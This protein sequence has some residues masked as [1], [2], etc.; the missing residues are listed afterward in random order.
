[1]IPWMS[2]LIDFSFIAS[3]HV[4]SFNQA[5]KIFSRSFQ[6]GCYLFKKLLIILGI[7]SCN[8]HFTFVQ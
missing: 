4:S 1:M 8:F 6:E 5:G 7:F 3:Y 2:F